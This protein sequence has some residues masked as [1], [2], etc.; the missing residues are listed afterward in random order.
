MCHS[1]SLCPRTIAVTEKVQG[2][3][4]TDRWCDVHAKFAESDN[5]LLWTNIFHQPAPLRNRLI[6]YQVRNLVNYY[7]RL[8]INF[9]RDRQTYFEDQVATREQERKALEAEVTNT[10]EKG[11]ESE[12]TNE[13]YTLLQRLQV[14]PEWLAD[15]EWEQF[16]AQG[17][18]CDPADN[19]CMAQCLHSKTRC[20]RCGQKYALASSTYYFCPSHTPKIPFLAK[21][22]NS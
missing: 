19:R 22:L 3:L 17:Q 6:T 12:L 18:E 1:G 13:E 21:A 2:D 14:Q 4:N 5:F 10:E 15:T 11:Q 9:T 8:H 7:R 20:K 16:C